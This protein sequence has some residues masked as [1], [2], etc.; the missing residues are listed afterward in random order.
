MKSGLS[1]ITSFSVL[2][3]FVQLGFAQKDIMESEFSFCWILVS[4]T[5]SDIMKAKIADQ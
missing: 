1:E 3:Q 5:N 2:V 4:T